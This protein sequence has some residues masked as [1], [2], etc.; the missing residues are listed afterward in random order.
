[1]STHTRNTVQRALAAF[2]GTAQ[3]T[4][5]PGV[6]KGIADYP[7]AFKDPATGG[8][9][10]API[11][12]HISCGQIGEDG[13][14]PAEWTALKLPALIVNSITSDP[15]DIGYEI[16]DVRLFAMTTA[17]EANA[18]AAVDDRAGW[19][20]SLFD[21]DNLDAIRDQLNAA[22]APVKLSVVGIV[23]DGTAHE[24]RDGFVM[25]GVKLKVHALAPA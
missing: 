5:A 14:L 1:M 9:Q 4:V 21:E 16:C 20:E 15:H 7:G 25:S 13:A 11:G 19:L 24:Q 12:I 23:R 3:V 6:V 22:D 17:E 10:A 8:M 2:L 18:P